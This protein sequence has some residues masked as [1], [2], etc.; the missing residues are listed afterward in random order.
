MA[1]QLI[2]MG[3]DATNET[4]IF[5]ILIGR[6]EDTLAVSDYL[7]EDGIIGTAIRP[8]TVPIGESRIRLT[9]TAAHNKRTNRLCVPIT[10]KCYE[11]VRIMIIDN[12]S[13]E[14]R[15]KRILGLVKLS[16]LD[17]LRRLRVVNI[18]NW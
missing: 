5:P 11:T 2:S 14:D 8:P 16:N 1:D 10:A 13:S 9:V 4:P 15:D 18:P 3:I 6:N 7:Y 17:K 12:I